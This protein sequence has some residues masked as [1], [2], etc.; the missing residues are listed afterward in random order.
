MARAFDLTLQ[1]Y[2]KLAK[3]FTDLFSQQ[4]DAQVYTADYREVLA[5]CMAKKIMYGVTYDDS[6]ETILNRI[7][8]SRASR[9][10]SSQ[11]E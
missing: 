10:M 5:R 3:L 11:D 9:M 8:S 1:R 4:T 7:N 6:I 2:E